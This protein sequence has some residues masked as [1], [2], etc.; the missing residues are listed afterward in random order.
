[1]DGQQLGDIIK[2]ERVARGWTQ[3]Y[4][5]ARLGG[6]IG[7]QTFSRWE[8]NLSKPSLETISILADLFHVDPEQFHLA[9]G[10]AIPTIGAPAMPSGPVRPLALTLPLPNLQPQVFE[11]FCTDL[12]QYLYRKAGVN[13]AGSQGHAQDGIDGQI[14]HPDGQRW[15]FQCKRRRQ[16]GPADIQKAVQLVVE[17]ADKNL[18]LLSRV[19]SPGARKEIRKHTGWELWD[20]EDMSRKIRQDIDPDEAVRLVETYFPGWSKD[21]LG[22]PEPGPWL[23]AAKFYRHS[24][25]NDFYTH[26]MSLVGRDTNL[27]QIGDFLDQAEAMFGMLVGRG[28]IGKTRL[29]RDVALSAEQLGWDVRFLDRSAQVL[30]QDCDLLPNRPRLLV[31]VDDAHE[32]SDLARLLSGLR[33]K[34]PYAKALLAIRPHGLTPII[35][36]LRHVGIHS[37][38]L[39]IWKLDDLQLS[40]AKALASEVLNKN[41]EDPVVAAL[42]RI[43]KDCPLITV[44]GGALIREG[45]LDSDRLESNSLIRNEILSA[46]RNAIVLDPSKGDPEL[47]KAVLEVVAAT[48]PFRVDGP[49][50][51]KTLEF[52]T[53][54]P[55]DRGLR[56]IHT[57]ED[58]GVLLRRGNSYRIVPDL[59]GDVVL[60]QAVVDERTGIDTGYLRRVLDNGTGKP[61]EN[62][63]VNAS[64]VDWQTR[65]VDDP[66]PSVTDSLWDSVETDLQFADLHERM[67]L[68]QLIGSVAFYE[69]NRALALVRWVM[70]HLADEVEESESPSEIAHKPSALDLAHCLPGI[71]RN[72]SYDY[73]YL[74]PALDFLWQLARMDG[75]PTN[76]FPDHALRVLQDLASFEIGKPLEYLV[77]VV[78]AVEEWLRSATSTD[79]HSPLDVVERLVVTEGYG[80]QTN[81]KTVSFEPYIIHPDVVAPLRHRVLSLALVEAENHDLKRAVRGVNTLGAGLQYPIG[82]FGSEVSE[83]EQDVWTPQFVETI[84][85]LGRL[86]CLPNVDP[87]VCIA[88]RRALQWHAGHSPTQTRNAASEA[89]ALIPDSVLHTMALYLHDGWGRLADDNSDDEDHMP[90][91]RRRH[92]QRT[93]FIWTL[94]ADY[95]V[96]AV[97]EMIA[98]RLSAERAGFGKT[99][100]SSNPAPFVAD[101]VRQNLDVGREMCNHV[102]CD[103]ESALGE[104]VA[105][106]LSTLA[107]GRCPD[108]VQC[109]RDLIASGHAIHVARA[110]GES[111]GRRIE[112][113][114]GE[115]ELLKNLANHP[116]PDVRRSAALGLS[117]ICICDRDAGFDVLAS[118]RF[119]DN[120]QVAAEVLSVIGPHGHLAWHDLSSDLQ[121][122]ILQQ[123]VECPSI[124]HYD[125]S[126]FLETLVE[127]GDDARV[128][129]LLRERIEHAESSEHLSVD[130]PL[131]KNHG[132]LIPHGF[133]SRASI[134]RSIRD[135]IFDR[136]DSFRRSKLFF[137]VAGST[138]E[139]A[140]NVLEELVWK[141]NQHEIKTIAKILTDAP[142]S[143]IWEQVDFVRR[144][145]NVAE[146]LGKDEFDMV[147]S[148]LFRS[149]FAGVQVGRIGEPFTTDERQDRA[150]KIADGF[151]QGS[152]EE[153]FY[154]AVEQYASSNSRWRAELDAD[155]L[156]DRNW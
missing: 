14:N 29:L 115:L 109:A 22:V 57:L 71:L 118:F 83:D 40:E 142:S 151:T 77:P 88:I 16:F 30:S 10:D 17:E 70:E 56:H 96:A 34:R 81:G 106:A 2:R 130:D 89:L 105:T 78:D 145:L 95:D 47:R 21:F 3:S 94:L 134:L 82:L 91:T 38:T 117:G 87:V 79:V 9:V 24:E 97:S 129:R 132:N 54:V 138:D 114:P 107:D 98:E 141:G 26:R 49:E 113:I 90:A 65:Q 5:V 63:F 52:L 84:E 66:R 32:Q 85:S 154:R 27:A 61:L 102:L 128:L 150:A 44:V 112:L 60:S 68:L 110:F 108:S 74:R 123:L 126:S 8:R 72:V 147:R 148:A 28:G 116:D 20:V 131:P 11:K 36:E 19:A 48:Q 119:D 152:T 73:D 136:P 75:R 62:L 137:Y 92:Q 155:L 25:S 18:L 55:L 146:S 80:S 133:P 156:D 58:S 33:S 43:S 100:T 46:Y 13:L 50:F 41:A 39:P 125:I 23:T 135:W 111:R 51:Q 153:Q 37:S 104:V 1:M 86:A 7:Q 149:T 124:D 4:V 76:R 120:T 93:S 103:P 67:H 12:M 143:L 31:V 121:G 45:K 53:G 140:V 69:P 59:L 139:E 99:N 64:R 122:S 127:T 35:D 144:V 15:T 6:R 101:V 42:A